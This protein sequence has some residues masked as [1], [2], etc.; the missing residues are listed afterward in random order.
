MP[1]PGPP[2]PSGTPE[3]ET[4]V[5]NPPPPGTPEAQ[6]LFAGPPTPGTREPQAP[7]PGPPNREGSPAGEGAAPAVHSPGDATESTAAGHPAESTAAGHPAESTAAGHPAEGAA[8]TRPAG[9]APTARPAD[10]ATAMA[11]AAPVERLEGRLGQL[12]R[13]RRGALVAYG[14][15][16][17]PD[18]DGSLAAFRAM[19][20]AGADVLEVG[21]PYSD[22][23]IDGPVIQRAVTGALE[24]GTRMDDVL[25]LVNELTASVDA[26]VVL[27]VYY[28]L[29]A[30]R[31][32]RR[33]AAEL[34]AAGACGAVVPDLPP[35]EA[36]EWLEAAAAAGIAPVFLAA[37]TSSD[38][39]L[40]AV[41]RAGRGFVY[42]QASLGVT[43][44]RASLAA[45]IEELVGRVR[46][47][48]DLPVCAGVGVSNAD[49]A[50]TVVRFADGAIVGTALVRRLADDGLDGLRA[51]TTELA[52]AVHTARS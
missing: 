42:A 10:G 17:Y 3:P 50:A 12:R 32:P 45:G 23:L 34:A 41:A 37:P 33:F 48:T 47:H 14:V 21:P 25:G 19:A 15:A 7:F 51:L 18:L 49:Q 39:R 38:A 43:G 4:L 24:A 20:E 52:T 26:P 16:G 1:D 30:H 36:Q 29:V 46:A 40:A 11:V 6:A 44:L 22:P 31:G 9:G 13:D 27:L 28:N 8:T 2:A 5:P 35:E